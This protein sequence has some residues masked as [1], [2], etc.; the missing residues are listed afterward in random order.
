[1]DG[2]IDKMTDGPMTRQTKQQRDQWTKTTRHDAVA[3]NKAGYT[4][5][6]APS[7]RPKI[8]GDGP[9]NGHTLL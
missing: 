4:A 6:D 1:M 5:Q 7:T 3:L 8:T 2:R 9:T